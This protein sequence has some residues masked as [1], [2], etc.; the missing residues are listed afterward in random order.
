MIVIIIII[1]IIMIIIDK[2]QTTWA[3]APCQVFSILPPR[4]TPVDDYDGGDDV[5]DYD[6]GDDDEADDDDDDLCLVPI[7]TMMVI[8]LMFL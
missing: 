7:L 5:D 6:D 3:S 2:R 4:L 1:N 8:S